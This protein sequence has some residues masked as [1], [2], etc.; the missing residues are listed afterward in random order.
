MPCGNG[1]IAQLE[2]CAAGPYPTQ[3]LALRAAI[4]EALAI[5]RAG[6]PAR[7]AVKS[8]SDDILVERCLCAS[9]PVTVA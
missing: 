4:D 7:V 3:D 9:F 5:R 8:A 6:R 1:W 2:H